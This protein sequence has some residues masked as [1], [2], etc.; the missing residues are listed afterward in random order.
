MHSSTE[1]NIQLSLFCDASRALDSDLGGIAV[2][3]KPWRPRPD[4]LHGPQRT[5]AAAYPIYPLRD[6]RVGEFIA[7]SKALF[8]ASQEIADV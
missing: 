8:I 7:I 3:Y 6:H 4:G 1:D 5:I 2:T